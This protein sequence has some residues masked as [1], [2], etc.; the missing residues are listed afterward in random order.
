MILAMLAGC[1]QEAPA[2]I[3]G[4]VKTAPNA[5]PDNAAK[6]KPPTPSLD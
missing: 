3:E 6:G 1:A 5:N 4:E 2:P